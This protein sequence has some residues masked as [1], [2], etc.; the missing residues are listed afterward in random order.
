L[1]GPGSEAW[2]LTLTPT[3]QYKQFFF[4][5]EVS[6]VHAEDFTS[7]VVFGKLGTESSQVRGLIETGVIF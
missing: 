4:R 5:G 7:G 1:Y 3:F 2:S 6:Y